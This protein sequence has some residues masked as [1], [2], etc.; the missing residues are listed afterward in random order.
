MNKDGE[1][2]VFISHSHI[3]RELAAWIKSELANYGL[4]AF[5]AHDDIRP[6]QR[7]QDVILDTLVKSQVFIALVSK[8]FAGSEW[9]DQETG[10][11]I[12]LAKLIIP[13][14]LDEDPYGFI[15]KFQAMKW[16]EAHR[17]RSLSELLELLISNEILSNESIIKAFSDSY[18]FDEAGFRAALLLRLKN[19]TKKDIDAVLIGA[20][21]N[22]QVYQSGKARSNLGILFKLHEEKVNPELKL[23]LDQLW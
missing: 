17:G 7:W 12:A 4:R 9:T 1:F 16:S 14:K 13:I 23:R 5:V 20:I 21:Q 8:D 15:G 19:L 2:E 6:T 18:S 3:D 22:R 11:A 10:V